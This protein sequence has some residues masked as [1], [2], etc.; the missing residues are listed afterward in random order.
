MLGAAL[1]KF[2]GASG[3]NNLHMSKTPQIVAHVFLVKL[4]CDENRVKVDG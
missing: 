3:T 2:V 1:S 4:F